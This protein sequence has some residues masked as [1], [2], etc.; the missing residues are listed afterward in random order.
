M[1]NGMCLAAGLT[2]KTLT[3]EGVEGL[4]QLM[5]KERKKKKKPNRYSSITGWIAFISILTPK[6]SGWKYIRGW[7]SLWTEVCKLRCDH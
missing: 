6:P 5:V 2:C 7:E 1:A 4:N 3:H